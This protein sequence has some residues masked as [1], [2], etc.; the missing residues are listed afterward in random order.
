MTWKVVGRNGLTTRSLTRLLQDIAVDEIDVAVIALGVND[1]KN[2]VPIRSWARHYAE[3]VNFLSNKFQARLVI[4]SGLPPFG[5][6]ELLPQP[7]RYVLGQRAKRFDRALA[8]LAELEE[9]LTHLPFDGPLER[10]MLARDRMHP[11]PRLYQI[12][13]ER[14][15]GAI[16]LRG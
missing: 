12:W 3:L 7:L 8:K 14:I 11:S 5:D 13:A 16:A 4:A 6:L 15:S 2:G 10:D 1:V 9:Q